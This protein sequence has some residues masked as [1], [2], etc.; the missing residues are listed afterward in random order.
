MTYRAAKRRLRIETM[1]LMPFVWAG[2][3][4]GSL[5]TLKTKHSVF[6]FFPNADIGGAPQV[7]IDITRCIKDK[8]PLIIFSKKPSNNLFRD[9]FNME[10]VRVIDLHRYIDNKLFH[11]VNMFFRGVLAAWINRVKDPVVFGGESIF[12]LKMLPHLKNS[13]RCI[14]LNHLDSWLPYSIRFA[15]RLSKRV[16]STRYLLDKVVK[17]YEANKLPSSFFDRLMFVENSIEIPTVDKTRNREMQVFFIGR[18]APQKRVHLVAAIARECHREKLPVHFHFVGNVEEQV[19][20]DSLPYCTFWGNVSDPAEMNRAYQTADVLLLTSS[21]E[22]LP[23]VVMQMMAHAK[24]VVSTTVG[25]IPDYIHHMENGLL[26]DAVEEQEIVAEGV[27][28]LKILAGDRVLWE[29]LGERSRDIAKKKFNA[30]TFCA[31]YRKL[32]GF[33]GSSGS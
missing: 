17:Q 27:R 21:F 5:F 12:F 8:N 19:A 9:K 10:G 24:V 28:Y 26:I 6:L 4:A 25:A 30:V 13:A 11:F 20:P 1:V 23:I 15:D 31:T 7:N 3:L 18:G 2:K 16:F 32:F 22:G 14:E 33:T 29:K